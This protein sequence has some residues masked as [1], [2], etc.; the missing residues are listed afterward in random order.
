MNVPFSRLAAIGRLCCLLLPG[1][2]T[3]QRINPV[4]SILHVHANSLAP[5]KRV[6]AVRRFFD[7]LEDATLN[8]WK[9]R[10]GA[11]GLGGDIST[12]SVVM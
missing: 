10:P 5:T 4:H 6:R 12:K 11:L 7:E 9:S 2:A 8:D 1:T 3:A